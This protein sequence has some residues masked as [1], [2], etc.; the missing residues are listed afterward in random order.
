MGFGHLKSKCL[1]KINS[2]YICRRVA[3][4]KKFKESSEKS[5]GK[6]TY[7]R[8]WPKVHGKAVHNV[9][10]CN[11]LSL[12]AFSQVHRV[13]WVVPVHPPLA[14]HQHYLPH[15]LQIYQ[16][17]YCSAWFSMNHSPILSLLSTRVS[18][19]VLRFL[20]QFET[21]RIEAMEICNM[22]TKIE[23]GSTSVLAV[24][25]IIWKSAPHFG[26]DPLL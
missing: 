1:S 12:I 10:M 24:L 2:D 26:Q 18:N 22:L 19:W 6:I 7:I 15:H 5:K 4:F 16:G 25:A 20:K 17:R 9:I 23:E 21:K 3:Q 8:I 13:L 11:I 14:H